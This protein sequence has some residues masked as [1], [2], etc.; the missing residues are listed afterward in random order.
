[1]H[2]LHHLEH[3]YQEEN[4]IM[5]LVSLGDIQ[6][7]EKKLTNFTLNF[8]QQRTP[9]TTSAMITAANPMTIAPRPALTSAN[10]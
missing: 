2:S 6:K 7:I 1:M 5:Q 9:N 8:P 4:E 3:R 10:P